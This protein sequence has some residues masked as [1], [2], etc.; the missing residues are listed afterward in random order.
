MNL[1]GN[2]VWEKSQGRLNTIHSVNRTPWKRSMTYF[3]SPLCFLISVQLILHSDFFFFFHFA[4]QPR[5]SPLVRSVL[6]VGNIAPITQILSKFT[7]DSRFQFHNAINL[8]QPVIASL[9]QFYQASVLTPTWCQ[10]IWFEVMTAISKST[11]P[12]TPPPKVCCVEIDTA[13]VTKYLPLI[14]S[15]MIFNVFLCVLALRALL[16]T[17]ANIEMLKEN[18]GA[19]WAPPPILISFWRTVLQSSKS[20]LYCMLLFSNSLCGPVVPGSRMRTDYTPA[21]HC[22][23]PHSGFALSGRALIITVQKTSNT[24]S[25]AFDGV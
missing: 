23:E 8:F 13:L 16:L 5:S 15:D 7:Q 25:I 20:S 21:R 4:P 17:R 22:S 1:Q 3:F 11:V 24:P 19:V 6:Y 14:P 18:T 2:V 9:H 12:R 10:N